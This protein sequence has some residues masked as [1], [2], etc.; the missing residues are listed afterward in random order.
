MWQLLQAIDREG[1]PPAGR[2]VSLIR[3]ALEGPRRPIGYR[4]LQ[5]VLQRMKVEPSKRL[6]LP[7]LGL[8]RLCLNDLYHS[9]GEGELMPESLDPDKPLKHPAFVCGQLLALYDYIQWKTNSIAGEQQP[10]AT[11]ADRFYNLCMVSPA[12]GF[13][14]V[15]QLGEK[16]LTKLRRLEARKDRTE[17][18]G[19][20]DTGSNA[21]KSLASSLQYR[22]AALMSILNGDF[23]RS[24]GMHDKARF[25]LGFYQQKAFRLKKLNDS[26]I[27]DSSEI[28]D[29]QEKE[30]TL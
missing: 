12:V 25:A 29:D 16:H 11:V 15:F 23:P 2:V 21:S 4:I 9:T 28:Q 27:V 8:L 14:A 19:S 13:S 20:I 22:L 17:R 7:S 26:E 24:F 10:N 1:K 5:D 30:S 3:R 6:S 18:A